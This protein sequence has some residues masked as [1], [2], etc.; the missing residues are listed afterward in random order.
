MREFIAILAICI[1]LTGCGSFFKKPDAII[2]EKVVRIDPEAMKPCADLVSITSPD[3]DTI[4]LVSIQNA[5]RYLDC[6]TRQDNSIKLLKQF[7]NQPEGK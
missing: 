3:Y 6:R 5:E 4:L 2:T 7:A 1:G